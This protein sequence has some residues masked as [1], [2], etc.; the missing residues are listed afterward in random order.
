MGCLSSKQAEHDRAQASSRRGNE[1]NPALDGPPDFGLGDAYEVTRFP[2]NRALGPPN[3]RYS[4]HQ[5]HAKWF[6]RLAHIDCASIY[7]T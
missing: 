4:L 5:M 6:A 2:T 1:Y 3:G 7:F